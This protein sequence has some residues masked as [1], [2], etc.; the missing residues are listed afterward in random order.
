MSSPGVG[1]GR[2]EKPMLIAATIT[3]YV[4]FY[5]WNATNMLQTPAF[6]YREQKK[7]LFYIMNVVCINV[8]APAKNSC[9]LNSLDSKF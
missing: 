6:N 5:F 1:S 2:T 3:L 8:Y 4:L 9:N 7:N